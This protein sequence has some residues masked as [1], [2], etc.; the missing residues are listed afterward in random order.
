MYSKKINFGDVYSILNIQSLFIYSK[1]QFA[2]VLN[3]YQTDWADWLKRCCCHSV[4]FITSIRMNQIEVTLLMLEPNFFLSSYF[5]DLSRFR[6]HWTRWTLL[7]NLIP[8]NFTKWVWV[9]KKSSAR[10]TD[11]LCCKTLLGQKNPVEVGWN[12]TTQVQLWNFTRS[13]TAPTFQFVHSS[14]YL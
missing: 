10:D 5:V 2:I 13:L 3:G 4:R 7:Q 14:L 9:L 8:L 1:T 11:R 12:T 6:L